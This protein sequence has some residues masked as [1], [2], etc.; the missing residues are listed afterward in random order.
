MAS[1][2]AAFRA[3]HVPLSPLSRR[4]EG[5]SKAGFTAKSVADWRCTVVE[6]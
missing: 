1:V 3:A 4:W 5:G 6:R 2:G